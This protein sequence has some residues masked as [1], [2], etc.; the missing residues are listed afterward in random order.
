MGQIKNIKLHIVTDIKYNMDGRSLAQA[1]HLAREEYARLNSLNMDYDETSTP[2]PVGGNRFFIRKAWKEILSS[3]FTC[4][5]TI[6]QLLL[7]VA[8]CVKYYNEEDKG[9]FILTLAVLISSNIVCFLWM[10][11]IQYGSKR[12]KEVK[13][14]V[15][16]EEKPVKGFVDEALKKLRSLRRGE[17]TQQQ[18]DDRVIRT[19]YHVLPSLRVFGYEDDA[20]RK[21]NVALP[22]PKPYL[23]LNLKAWSLP[24]FAL[25][26][27]LP[28]YLETQYL[29]LRRGALLS[30][31]HN[32]DDYH[33]KMVKCAFIKNV[34]QMVLL[35]DYGE[36]ALQLFLQM[37]IMT[38]ADELCA[39]QLAHICMGVGSML[40][41]SLN[42]QTISSYIVINMWENGI[43]SYV[44]TLM[45]YLSIMLLGILS[46]LTIFIYSGIF[47]QTFAFVSLPIFLVFVFLLFTRGALEKVRKFLLPI[48]KILF[49]VL[50]GIFVYADVWWYRCMTTRTNFSVEN[51]L[52]GQQ[53]FANFSEAICEGARAKH[54]NETFGI[55]SN[56]FWSR[57]SDPFAYLSPSY[58][59]LFFICNIIPV[60]LLLLSFISPMYK[61]FE[62]YHHA[63]PRIQLGGGVSDEAGDIRCYY[64]NME[65]RLAAKG[66]QSVIVKAM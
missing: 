32:G 4:V 59:E 28:T 9:W 29:R 43:K 23:S 62:Y 57:A 42:D 37:Y 45:V 18:H 36:K 14:L 17:S 51:H 27:Q 33:R 52:H 21:F 60:F 56:S 16:T 53:R 35:L 15:D 13:V 19:W 20:G 10:L 48:A 58:T 64:V 12:L 31:H 34:L 54:K 2:R 11:S 47:N 7:D 6:I 63:N 61:G 39:L 30:L 49:W 22:T 41:S 25:L 3:L 44:G 24:L 65:R 8:L 26:G 46:L 40:L 38:E 66:I 50:F 55:T 1:M 5:R